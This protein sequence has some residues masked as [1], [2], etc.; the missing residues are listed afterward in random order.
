VS[1]DEPKVKPAPPITEPV[2]VAS[3]PSVEANNNGQLIND[4]TPD[5]K[6]VSSRA[7][8]AR[9]DREELETTVRSWAD[10]WSRQQVGRYL[11][12]YSTRFRPNAGVSIKQWKQ[13]RKI[14]I[15]SKKNIRVE[16]SDFN[17]SVN[18]STATV[19][20]QQAYQSDTF[21]DVIRKKLVLIR[22][23]EG[24]KIVREVNAS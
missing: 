17:A 16:L 1:A 2:K 4:D 5:L 22:G 6:P 19:L 8:S 18:G 24:W 14:R 21:S 7:E 9:D 13:Q 3:R 20:F 12:F 15:T 23:P 11:S 10:A